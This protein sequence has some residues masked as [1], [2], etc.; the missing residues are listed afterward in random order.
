MVAALITDTIADIIRGRHGHRH[1]RR[2][3][4]RQGRNF[5]GRNFRG[6]QGRQFEE[7]A[8]SSGGGAAGGSAIDF[9]SCETQPDGM[10]CVI[11]MS[12]VKSIKKD[13]ILECTHKEIEKCHYTYVTEF[14]PSQEEV[15]DENFEK[16]CQITFKKMATTETVKKCY[17]PLEK[18]CG[19]GQS[20]SQP[21]FCSLLCKL[22]FP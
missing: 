8:L 13:P 17:T 20:Q 12:S 10:C 1:G 4:G 9:S 18:V 15:C 3:R 16:K 21:G 7:N 22:Q 14:I 11:K 19:E 5:R 6:R 2:G